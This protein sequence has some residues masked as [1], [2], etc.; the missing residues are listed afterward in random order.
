MVQNLIFGLLIKFF[1]GA[2][3]IN[4][5]SKVQQ[6]LFKKNLCQ[7]GKGITMFCADEKIMLMLQISN[8][9]SN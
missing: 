1:F 4:K 5:I 9:Y 3:I 8:F 7:N 6:L 2:Q